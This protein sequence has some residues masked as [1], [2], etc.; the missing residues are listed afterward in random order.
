MGKRAATDTVQKQLSFRLAAP[1][2]VAGLPRRSVRTIR[3]DGE[4]GALV[5]YGEGLG[6]LMVIQAPAGGRGGMDAGGGPGLQE[7]SIDGATGYELATALGT[8]VQFERD[9]VAY[10]IV[11]SVP[12]AAAEAAARAL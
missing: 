4:T 12:P 6:A 11:G 2:A 7:L 3:S 1:A 9:G 5:T 10:T 8:L